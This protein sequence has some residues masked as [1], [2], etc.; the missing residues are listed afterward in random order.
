MSPEKR[1]FVNSTLDSHFVVQM[2]Q[3]QKTQTELFTLRTKWQTKAKTKTKTP[4]V[5]PR[6]LDSWFGG[7]G[8]TT[9]T[10]R[11]K[12]SLPTACTDSLADDEVML[13]RVKVDD[14]VTLVRVKASPPPKQ[15]G[16]PRSFLA[17][18]KK[19]SL[20]DE[21]NIP[22]RHNP[23]VAAVPTAAAAH[24]PAVTTPVPPPRPPA[25]P[26]VIDLTDEIVAYY[27]LAEF[28]SMWHMA[29]EDGQYSIEEIEKGS[30]VRSGNTKVEVRVTM[31]THVCTV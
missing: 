9:G 8:S 7:T 24:R 23:N 11:P 29:E 15:T 30:L 18:S 26:P 20:S 14:K 13:A 27:T 3:R 16:I 12:S 17:E 28:E 5:D 1:K 19:R 31:H 25:S 22:I 2:K 4:G 21:E 10:A 6:T